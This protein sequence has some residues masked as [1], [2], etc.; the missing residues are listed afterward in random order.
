MV[1]LR[2]TICDACDHNRSLT[3]ETVY[4]RAC[5]CIDVSLLHG[6]CRLQKWP[7][8][9]EIDGR[10]SDISMMQSGESPESQTQDVQLR[11][12]FDRIVCINLD[13]S[14]DRWSVFQ[15]GLNQV[16]WQFREIERFRAVD[17]S[18]VRPPKW[19]RAG[20]GAWGCHQSHVRILEEAVADGIESLLILEDDAVFPQGFAERVKLFLNE[21]PQDWDGLMLGGNHFLPPK[22]ISENVVRAVN[23]RRTHAHAYRGGY[24]TRA[25]R[26]LCNY[27]EHAEH[28]RLHVDSRLGQLHEQQRDKV[29]APV[30]WLVGQREGYSTIANM[31]VPRRFWN[32]S[33]VPSTKKAPFVA[34]IGLHRS[35]SSCLAGVLHKLGVHLGDDLGGYEKTGGFEAASL[36]RICEQAYP[37]PS[38]SQR[39]E[40]NELM[41]HLRWFIKE[42]RAEATM[43]N[44]I[45]GGKY[46]TLCAMGNQLLEACDD[47]RVI[48]INRPLEDSIR[49]L[50]HRLRQSPQPK[51][52][53]IGKAEAVQ[54]WLWEHKQVFLS[55]V[56]HLTIEYGDLLR[57]PR[58]EIN[59]IVDYLGISPSDEQIEQ[60]VAHVRPDLKTF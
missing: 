54:R 29:Y 3:R 10:E 15:E 6:R 46:P 57:S 59:R 20:R 52:D 23:V 32:F 36:A 31:K 58:T 26:H 19:W 25:Y 2:R 56:E 53:K 4:C 55:Q 37:F 41:P 7:T 8:P 35:G 45:A 9:E 47:L 11:H 22:P 18:K 16:D 12:L 48:H 38:T 30:P 21:V 51:T 24:I 40:N 27:P 44:T 33:G 39:M 49:S 1:K 28:P 5:N 43:M 50:E 60:A 34:V 13:R 42:L 14:P 17:G